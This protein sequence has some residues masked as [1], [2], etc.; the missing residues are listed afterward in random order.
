[1]ITT[2]QS[3][4]RRP[5]RRS[6]RFERVAQEQEDSQRPQKASHQKRKLA[7][8]VEALFGPD[9]ADELRKRARISAGSTPINDSK[10]S[11]AKSSSGE[12]RKPIKY[13]SEHKRWPKEYFEQD[14]QTRDYLKRDIEAESWCKKYWQ[15][16]M[17]HLLAR[18]KSATSLARKKS[19]VS[20]VTP[21]STTPSDEKPREAKSAP[22]LRTSYATI[23]ASKG[24]FMDKSEQGITI[25]SKDVCKSLLENEQ[26]VPLESL[27]HDDL[28]DTTCRNLSDRNEA[29]IIRDIGLLIVP[30]AQT[31]ATYGAT[32]LEF[33]TEGVNEG[34]NSAIPF[35]G[36]RPQPDYSV[37]F[38]RSAFTNNQLEMLKPFVGDIMDSILPTSWPHGECISHSS[39]AR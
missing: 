20:S 14:D 21:S 4:P 23:L 32:H 17:S 37:G 11:G 3:E 24:S 15:P 18:K 16:D 28:F 8:E 13:W 29:M 6:K 31:L 26:T 9:P 25:R 33:L 36:P 2:R 19:D 39:R 7:R 10:A 12:D 1:M 5:L 34:W 30:S 35:Y 27:F 22:Y 38:G